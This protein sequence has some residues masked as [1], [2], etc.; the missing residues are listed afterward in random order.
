MHVGVVERGEELAF[1]HDGAF[2]EKDAG[3]AAGDFRGDGG[4]A[5]RGDVAAGIQKG[6]AASGT[7]G[8]V[9]GGDFDDGLL[10][11]ERVDTTGDAGENYE[12]AEENRESLP[13]FAAFALTFVDAQGSE[14]MLRRQWCGH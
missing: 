12:D 9:D 6:F 8:F 5:A 4:A 13:E 1:L 11:P 10:I 2:V 14:I 3:D 7:D